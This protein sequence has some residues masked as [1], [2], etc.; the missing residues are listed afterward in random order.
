MLRVTRKR[1]IA[2]VFIG[3]FSVAGACAW[4]AVAGA[5]TSTAIV[6]TGSHHLARLANCTSSTNGFYQEIG[7]YSPGYNFPPAMATF[8]FQSTFNGYVFLLNQTTASTS[9][10]SSFYSQTGDNYW[11]ATYYAPNIATDTGFFTVAY[12]G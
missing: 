8:G 2:A 3:L 10:S 9:Q 1:A 6:K 5:S 11:F 7:T 4:P 12:C